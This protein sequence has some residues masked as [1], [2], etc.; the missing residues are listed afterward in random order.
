[1][2]TKGAKYIRDLGRERVRAQPAVE[3]LRITAAHHGERLV[4]PCVQHA[5]GM[6]SS[7]VSGILRTFSA[8]ELIEACGKQKEG[9]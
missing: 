6:H 8:A 1:V 2:S 5:P 3:H 7:A 4:L 9:S